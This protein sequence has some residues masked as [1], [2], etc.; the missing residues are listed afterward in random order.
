MDPQ[1]PVQTPSAS[2]WFNT[3]PDQPSQIPPSA[4]PPK[5]KRN[6]RRIVAISVALFFLLSSISAAVVI[7]NITLAQPCLTN[8]DY[9]I[10]TGAT[11]KDNISPQAFYAASLEYKLG[12]SDFST[13]SADSNQALI[14]KIGAFYDERSAERSIIIT[15][16]SDY[17]DSDSKQL[18]SKRIDSLEDALIRAGVE[19]SA[20]VKRTPTNF[21]TSG[22]LNEEFDRPVASVAYLGIA[23]TDNCST[24]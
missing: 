6:R 9:A 12:T 14:K 2:D 20:I 22:D 15:I 11:P 18:A 24:N 21:T 4:E 16:S 10:I 3:I 1:P 17:G 23:S 13:D 5:P 19:P 8:D 7:R